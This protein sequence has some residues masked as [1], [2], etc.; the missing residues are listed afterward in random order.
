MRDL[1]PIIQTALSEVKAKLIDL[2]DETDPDTGT[3]VSKVIYLPDFDSVF[4]HLLTA[5]DELE[6]ITVGEGLA[7]EERVIVMGDSKLREIFDELTHVFNKYRSHVRKQY[8][9][10]YV[11]I[12]SMLKNLDEMTTSDNAGSYLSNK[13]RFKKTKLKEIED[14]DKDL[15]KFIKDRIDSFQTVED[16]L[17]EL[18]PLLQKA[19]KE[20]IDYYTDKPS[21]NILYSNDLAIDYLD[22][23]IKM[24]K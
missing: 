11:K 1:I 7:K 21:F 17:N 3:T 23:M 4:E 20:T 5:L 12:K 15:K 18:I 8:P 9:D 10:E 19:K 24:F 6:A 13:V 14:V 2:P 16:K 22:D